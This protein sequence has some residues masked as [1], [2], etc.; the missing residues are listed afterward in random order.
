MV[1]CSPEMQ[2]YFDRV[3]QEVSLAY[4]LAKRAREQGLDPE[5]TVPIPL[6]ENMAERVEGL[7]SSVAPQIIG[8]GITD[9]IVELEKEHGALGWKVALE[10]AREVAEQKFCTFPSKREAIEVGIRTGFAYHTVGVVAA[11]L[12]GFVELKIKKRADG[13]EYFSVLFSGPIRG[14][15]GTASAV[16]LLIA[17]YIRKKFGYAPYD[18]TELEVKRTVTELYDYHD[19]VTNLQ[20]KP[21]EE[22]I[23]CIAKNLPIEVSG[24][25]TEL[26][27]VS[28]YKDLPRIETNRIRGGMCLVL[29][30][31]A[32]KAPKLWKQLDKWGH[33]FDLEQWDWIETFLKIQKTAKAKSAPDQGNANAEK[34]KLTPDTTFIADLVS[35][36]PVITHPMA[37]GG[38][39][40]RYGR[41][42]TSG[43]SSASVHPATMGVLCDY[44]ALG[45]QLKTERP[46][47]AASCT[48]CDTIEGPTVLLKDGSVVQPRSYAE[49][50]ALDP[51]VKEVLYLGDVLFSYGD[52]FD[53]AHPLVP[54]GITE[55]EWVAR[56]LALDEKTLAKIKSSLAQR[57][58]AIISDPHHAIPTYDEA[59]IVSDLSGLFLHPKYTPY[60]RGVELTELST[61]VR[62]LQS[63]TLTS[64][65]TLRLD[66]TDEKR[67]L[68]L[69]GVPHTV[70]Q[71][72]H[73]LIDPGY[74]QAIH[75]AFK[76]ADSEAMSGA[77]HLE[78]INSISAIPFKDKA[79]TFVGA[80]MGRPEKGK[81][82]KMTGSPHSLFPVGDE[83][84]RMRSFQAAIAQKTV[85]ADFPEYVLPDGTITI[86]PT[87][88]NT[89]N[90]LELTEAKHSRRAIDIKT[91]FQSAL[92]KLGI[93]EFPDLIKGVRGTMNAKRI[94][95]HIAKG[96]LRAEH[97]VY[98][99][100]DGTIRY[101]MTELP[102]THFKSKEIRTSVEKLRELGYHKD[103]HGNE[104]TD[105]N[106]VCELKPQ[107]IILGAAPDSPEDGADEALFKISR[108]VDDELTKLYKLEPYYN[109]ETKHDVVGVYIIGLAPHTSAGILGRVIGFSKTQ[110][111]L[112]HPL[113]H[114][115]MRRDT[116]GDESCVVMLMDGLLNFSREY[117]PDRRGSR[118]MDA[119]LVLTSILDP[120]EVDDMVHNLDIGWSY[121]VALYDAADTYSPPWDVKINLLG[122]HLAT[123]QQYE[124]M[125][126][127]HDTDDINAGVTCSAYKLLPSMQE[128]LY[129]QMEIAERVRAVNKDHVAT[130]V[131][132]KHLI[133]DIRGNLRKFSQ[134][135]FRCVNCNE[136]FR[137][138]P[139]TSTCTKC[140]GKVIFTISEGS[141]IK[142]LEPAKS[143]VTAYH[144]SPYLAQSIE[145]LDRRIVS[146]FGRDTE[147]QT[148]LGSWF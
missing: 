44:I 83:G 39:R 64:E 90:E 15:G 12:E 40:L 11:P 60:W 80:R 107:D 81:M 37:F 23:E 56:M 62:Y 119:P 45:T 28:N 31:V 13:K 2:A 144:L 120:A 29:S 105:E 22:E 17:D 10:I 93:V 103:I 36:R 65:G 124:D 61:L 74:A 130:L 91:Y 109:F 9:R 110:S 137:R 20:Y 140:N 48:S 106:Q 114:A 116:D 77:D 147:K 125:G 8:S 100:K 6:A 25:P 54:V 145:I 66:L 58:D 98:V 27:E 43:Y 5:R 94:P 136:K 32:L 86:Y 19:R 26:I 128:K 122:K 123:P 104:L 57:Y 87:D 131:I 85:T 76:D 59:R 51:D 73:V 141:V 117:L 21:S 79:G 55:E 101:D 92:D 24:D 129:G 16:S 118:T 146:V 132:E 4:N 18:P 82:R 14:A 84:G 126:F 42:R 111:M 95:E 134:Q 133:R 127:T 53:R 102:I 88:E 70:I 142:Y 78:R 46:G 67:S 139:L 52:F 72:T 63:G 112:C 113:F 30:M 38:L 69:I 71:N 68:E 35:G 143:L 138:P 7:I 115:A 1:S 96:I 34:P 50:K 75:D 108:F 89:G 41:S 49:A 121:P 99:N 97:D 135:Q 33:D 3:R 148:G 47:K